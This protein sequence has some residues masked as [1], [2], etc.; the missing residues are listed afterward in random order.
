MNTTTTTT[1]LDFGRTG[2]FSGRSVYDWLF[3]PAST[4]SAKCQSYTL[5]PE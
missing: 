3:A 1:T 5:R 4:A 2:Y